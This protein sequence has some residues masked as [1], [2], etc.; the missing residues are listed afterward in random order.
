MSQSRRDLVKY[1]AV[2]GVSLSASTTA[3]AAESEQWREK[4]NGVYVMPEYDGA[5]SLSLHGIAIGYQS[6]RVIWGSNNPCWNGQIHDDGA[7]TMRRVDL[8]FHEYARRDP[9]AYLTVEIPAEFAA[10]FLALIRPPRETRTPTIVAV[11]RM[12]AGAMDLPPLDA[13]HFNDDPWRRWKIIDDRSRIAERH[14][15]FNCIIQPDMSLLWS[16]KTDPDSRHGEHYL[17]QIEWE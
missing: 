7:I 17:A 1:L 11:H 10:T 15:P 6:G 4:E 8:R 12:A 5:D 3:L 14:A 16:G 13:D 9:E 2:I